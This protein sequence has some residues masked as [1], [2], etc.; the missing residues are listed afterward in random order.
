M[1]NLET[2]SGKYS[3]WCERRPLVCNN[4]LIMSKASKH[5]RNKEFTNIEKNVYFVHELVGC[6]GFEFI[7][8]S[9]MKI[10]KKLVLPGNIILMPCFYSDISGKSWND[11]LVRLT[12]RM[13]MKARFVYDG[14][15]PIKDW[16][17]DNVR[18]KMREIEEILSLFSLQE[19]ISITWEPKYNI[20]NNSQSSHQIKDGHIQE[21][22]HLHESLNEF[23]DEDSKAFYKSVAW[24]SHSL[25]LPLSPSRFLL[26]FVA[27]ESFVN[28]IENKANKDSLF[29]GLKSLKKVNDVD[30]DDCIELT[31]D[32][33]YKNN[34]IEAI[35]TA[36]YDCIYL[37]ITKTL[38]KHL[39]KTFHDDKKNIELIFEIKIEGKTLY[40]LRHM[41][42]HGGLDALSDIQRQVINN[43]IWQMETITREYFIKVIELVLGKTP[44]NEVM[45]KSL[46]FPFS[47]ASKEEQYRGPLHIAEIYS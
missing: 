20:I 19:R 33:I 37:S 12:E 24:L 7:V 41:I 38:K 31:L 22:I 45:I 34:K 36:F 35:R 40:E 43:R 14:W 18:K 44:F 13:S 47:V 17:I 15:I 21:I 29:L 25:T 10:G 5:L 30:M 6:Q 1:N 8:F 27:L 16:S 32:R 42:A 9:S 23:N 26:C 39:N 2:A 3:N 11:S 46:S 28:Y 4:K